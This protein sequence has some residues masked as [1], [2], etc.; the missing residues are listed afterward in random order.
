MQIYI[1]KYC[2]NGLIQVLVFTAIKRTYLVREKQCG[3]PR[4]PMRENTSSCLF[5]F[6]NINNTFSAR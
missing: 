5:N 4:Y 1:I 2:D 3:I 6:P